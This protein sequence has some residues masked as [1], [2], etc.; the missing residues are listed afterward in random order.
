MDESGITI[1]TI[2][3]PTMIGGLLAPQMT[4]VWRKDHGWTQKKDSCVADK[5]NTQLVIPGTILKT[6]GVFKGTKNMAPVFKTNTPKP[7]AD[8]TF[9]VDEWFATLPNGEGSV[10]YYLLNGQLSLCF[11]FCACKSALQPSDGAGCIYLV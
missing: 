9:K 4:Q 2:T 5:S 8:G 10:T 1:K 11:L 3:T 7:Q 6:S